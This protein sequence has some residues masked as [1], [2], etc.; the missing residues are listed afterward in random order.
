M[1]HYQLDTNV[2]LRYLTHD[3][4]IQAKVVKQLFKKAQQKK[5]RVEVSEPVF[6]EITVAL[7][8]YFK[9][10]KIKVVPLLKTLLSL[11][12]ISF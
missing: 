6:I 2:L 3:I 5:V 11:T 8:N 4:P 12:W 9:F 1:T 7:R 10:P